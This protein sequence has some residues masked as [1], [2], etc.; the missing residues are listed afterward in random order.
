M[1]HQHCRFR[2]WSNHSTDYE[3]RA[4]LC[5]LRSIWPAWTVQRF[6]L[7]HS[8]PPQCGQPIGLSGQ[9][10]WKEVLHGGIRTSSVRLLQYKQLERR[11]LLHLRGR[12]WDLDHYEGQGMA[13]DH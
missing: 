4:H 12:E 2:V 5:V 6:E 13:A 7:G 8:I 3:F 1:L 9:C 10:R 11:E